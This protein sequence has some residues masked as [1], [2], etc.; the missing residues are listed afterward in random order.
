MKDS[1]VLLATQYYLSSNGERQKE[2]DKCLERNILNTEI[3]QYVIF[4]ENEEAYKHFIELHH[5]TC[6][7]R[8][9]LE[10]ELKRLNHFNLEIIKNWQRPTFND[11]FDRIENFNDNK[12]YF[13]IIANT[14]I[15]LNKDSINDIKQYLEPKEAYCLSRWDIKENESFEL[16]NRPDSQDTFIYYGKLIKNINAPFVMGSLGQD[17]KLCYLFKEAGYEPVNPSHTIKTFH[18]HL[19]DFRTYIDKDGNRLQKSVDPPY[20]TLTP[21][22][23][24]K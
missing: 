18:L 22:E 2:I 20:L 17:N 15:F 8:T 4:F 6:G 10:M 24:I 9:K 21:V 16:F 14:D 23:I 7:Q 19:S 3:N 13:N 5:L 12:K 1:P 11:I